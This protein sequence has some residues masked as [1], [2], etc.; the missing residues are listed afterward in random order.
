MKKGKGKNNDRKSNKTAAV[1]PV[2]KHNDLPFNWDNHK[3]AE[4]TD[5]ELKALMKEELY[6]HDKK[7]YV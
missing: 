5:A 6:K 7:G 4:Y 1:S 3:R 2:K